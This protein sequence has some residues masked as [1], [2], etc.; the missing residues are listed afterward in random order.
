MAEWGWRGEDPR[1]ERLG[2]FALVRGG[3]SAPREMGD[4]PRGTQ[5]GDRASEGGRQ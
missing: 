3:S 4:T 2:G 5:A 1:V